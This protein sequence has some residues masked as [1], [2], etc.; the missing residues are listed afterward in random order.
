MN[1]TIVCYFSASG[2]TKGVAESLANMINADLFEIEKYHKTVLN[3]CL[4]C[5][6]L[7]NGIVSQ[8]IA[9][10]NLVFYRYSSSLEE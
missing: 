8:K 5:C 7:C 2:T 4:V 1:K 9:T 3:K 6:T 10:C